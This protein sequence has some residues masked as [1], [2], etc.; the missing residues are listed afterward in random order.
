MADE[1]KIEV[2]GARTVEVKF[3]K[4]P[5]E[6]RANLL[7]GLTA[8]SAELRDAVVAK[9]PSLSGKLRSETYGKVFSDPSAVSAYVAVAS[10]AAKAAA[11]E[12][13]SRGKRFKTKA[14][15]MRLDHVFNERLS[16][17]T[18]VFVE[19]YMRSRQ[20][21][22]FEFLRG[23]LTALRG[24]AVEVIDAALAKTAAENG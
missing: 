19:T 20:A 12:Y 18:T 7:E 14:H 16:S 15:P 21:A 17:P 6:A 10:G 3:D 9:E 22:A 8:F 5:E 2:K 4:F 11:L 1:I 24:Q 13:G 23:T